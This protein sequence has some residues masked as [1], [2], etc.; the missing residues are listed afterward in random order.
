[1]LVACLG[2]GAAA[3]PPAAARTGEPVVQAELEP[4]PEAEAPPDPPEHPPPAP[5]VAATQI[6]VASTHAC[7]RMADGTARCWGRNDYGQLADGTRQ[8]TER[9]VTIDL[10]APIDA[11]TAGDGFTC[12]SIGGD[13]QC[14]GEGGDG[15]LGTGPIEEAPR[16]WVPV[17][18]VSRARAIDGGM[19]YACAVID[20]GAVRCWGNND[21]RQLGDGTSERR[22][23]SV[24]V[25]GLTGAIGLAASDNFACVVRD[26]ESLWCWGAN[27]TRTA[28]RVDL[29]EVRAVSVAP[30]GGTGCAVAGGLA[31]CWGANESG[32]AGVDPYGDEEL[33]RVD[34]PRR[35]EGLSGVV[36]VAAGVRHACALLEDH[37][38]R[39]WGAEETLP[40]FAESCLRPTRNR[41]RGG[42][43]AQW[44]YCPEPTPVTALPPVAALDAAGDRTC[45]LTTDGAVYCWGPGAP[46]RIDLE[47][48]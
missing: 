6:S 8:P 34:A 19:G 29:A 14:L 21:Y 33:A 10:G 46:A 18:G 45:A 43:A 17:R 30:G 32:Q 13:V 44:R 25:R 22:V 9:A 2:C 42:S 40:G 23:G 39:C 11:I 38:V 48:R 26:D 3:R 37:T 27:M 5:G 16:R 35:V 31:H 36:G 47:P 12:L 20:G 28:T 24:A 1:M 41:S 15:Q 4:E 7:A